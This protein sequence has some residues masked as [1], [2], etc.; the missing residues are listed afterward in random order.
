MEIHKNS[1]TPVERPHRSS[2]LLVLSIISLLLVAAAG[3]YLTLQKSA[4]ME[5]QKVLDADIASLNTEID[6]LE[7]LKVQSAQLAQQFLASVEKDE[8]Q[9]SRVITR[10]QSLLPVDNATQ[11]SKFV[12]ISYNGSTGGKL[13]LN[14]ETVPTA[15]EPFPTLAELLA[16]FNGSSFFKN[17]YVPNIS[18][19]ET[20]D[21]R[22]L[23]TF[24][25]NLVYDED[26]VQTDTVQSL[27]NGSTQESVDTKP[28]V[29]RNS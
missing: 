22:K 11:Q 2:G 17:A 23:L 28:K 3:V 18:R 24:T 5:E 26:K 19:G 13:T 8:V 27:T 29:S 16:T 6:A 15:L 9:W 7:E 4:L 21:G 20:D 25:L 1:P 10:I 14:M 12:V